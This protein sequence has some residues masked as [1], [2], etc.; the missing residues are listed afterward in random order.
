M[1]SGRQEKK[2]LGVVIIVY[3]NCRLGL[4]PLP[5]CLPVSQFCIYL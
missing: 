5:M 1:C 3:Q 4:S 2:G